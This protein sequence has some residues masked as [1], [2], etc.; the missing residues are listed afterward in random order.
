MAKYIT[1]YGHYVLPEGSAALVDALHIRDVS[2]L[3]GSTGQRVR[4]MRT[5]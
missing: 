2:W 1:L 4:R 5:I 3:T